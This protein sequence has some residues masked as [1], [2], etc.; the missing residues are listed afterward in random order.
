MLTLAGFRH[1]RLCV[2]IFPDVLN[3]RSEALLDAHIHRNFLA[4]NAK[5]E[6][7]VDYP[8]T[9]E[10]DCHQCQAEGF[11][12]TSPVHGKSFLLGLD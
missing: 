4:I 10:V 2:T 11:G 1:V 7:S 6:T 12:D 5:L 3:V 8:S 9:K